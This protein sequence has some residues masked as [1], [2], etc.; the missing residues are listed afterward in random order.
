MNKILILFVLIA[1]FLNAQHQVG[2]TTLDEREVVDGL[3][4]PWEIKWGPDSGDGE[5]FLWVTE[6]NGIVSRVN[7]DTGEKYII[8]DTETM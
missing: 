7:V 4:V 1:G 6:R 5:N 2:S 3:D 8:L